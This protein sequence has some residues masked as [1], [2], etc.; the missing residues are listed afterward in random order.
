MFVSR[1]DL[2]KEKA[3]VGF[4]K[5]RR[6]ARDRG[7]KEYG[8]AKT[9][10]N[11][12]IRGVRCMKRVDEKGNTWRFRFLERHAKLA[13]KSGSVWVNRKKFIYVNQKV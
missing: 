2:N 4:E 13:V 7:Y 6:I 8:P 3:R 9:L 1:Q 5:I 10:M 12:D 11:L